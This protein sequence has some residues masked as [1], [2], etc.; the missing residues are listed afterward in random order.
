MTG[1]GVSATEFLPDPGAIFRETT[2][3]IG[4][5]TERVMVR[6]IDR[7]WVLLL[8][9]FLLAWLA[10]GGGV[11]GGLTEVRPPPR[12]EPSVPEILQHIYGVP[13]VPSGDDYTAGAMTARRLLDEGGTGL[14]GRNPDADDQ[15]WSI[16]SFHASVVAKF[17]DRPQQFGVLD[18]SGDIVS[19]FDA[20]G[21]G[22]EVS[23]EGTYHVTGPWIW[24]FGNGQ[25][26]S[27]I[28]DNA[29][30]RD[31]LVTYEM[32]LKGVATGTYFLFWEDL[33]L[34][35]STPR[36]RSS[37]DFNDLVIRVQQIDTPPIGVVPLPGGTGGTP[38]PLPAGVW[39]ALAL[40]GSIF[41]TTPGGSRRR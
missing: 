30:S 27:R 23:G 2:P 12:G 22:Y 5:E 29:D 1:F 20:E 17:Y 24:R 35:A 4:A 34:R 31:H 13:F 39:A 6:T 16:G 19:L 40:L 32:V 37:H 7:R 28:E 36:G 41:V 8:M 26:A 10:G 15:N 33:F 25:F 18:P 3:G 21:F 9:A 14:V 11:R 38:I